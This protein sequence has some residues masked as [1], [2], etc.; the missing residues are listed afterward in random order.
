[1]EYA[2][3]AVVYGEMRTAL[4]PWCSENSYK[5]QPKTDASWMKVL[6]GNENLYFGLHCARWGGALLGGNDFHGLIQTEPAGGPPGS[7]I[8][9][10]TNFSLCLLQP[11]LDELCE[12]QNAINRRRP[13]TAEI[14]EW[15]RE[16]SLL[17]EHNRS[18]YKQFASGEKP[19]RVG[20]FPAFGYFS[21]EDVRAHLAFLSRR[22]PDI[23]ARFVEGRVAV[24]NPVPQPAF[25]ARLRPRG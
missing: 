3:A 17:G 24:P 1:M 21:L 16:D 20:D 9:R 12:I 11:E 18:K 22:L 4:G 15:M 25:M 8:L 23:V 13:R 14:E 5:R 7:A 10:Q 6:E 19:Y 2:R